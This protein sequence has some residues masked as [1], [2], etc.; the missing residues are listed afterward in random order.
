VIVISIDC[1]PVDWAWLSLYFQQ[2]C[3]LNCFKLP[4]QPSND[5]VLEDLVLNDT[6]NSFQ[7][8]FG[9]TEEVQRE[10]VM[11]E[12]NDRELSSLS[13]KPESRTNMNEEQWK[14]VVSYV[15]ARLKDEQSFEIDC[16]EFMKMF[17]FSEGHYAQMGELWQGEMAS[18][19]IKKPSPGPASPNNDCS[20]G[21]NT[22][23]RTNS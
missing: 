10:A 13:G 7:P 11:L 14:E 4:F 20:C 19:V 15:L 3:P 5:T 22:T 16:F 9:S 21:S 2:I 8:H 18:A 1:H 12:Q 17:G 6:S 23:P